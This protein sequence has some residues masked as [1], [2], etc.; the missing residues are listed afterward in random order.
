MINKLLASR[1][2]RIASVIL[3]VWTL[4]WLVSAVYWEGS[5]VPDACKGD[6]VP[7][8]EFGQTEC[9]DELGR[10]HIWVA[11]DWLFYTAMIVGIP[12]ATTLIFRIGRWVFE[13]KK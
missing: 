9:V 11:A 8:L 10:S 1:N 7:L 3:G 6:G 13:G 2:A 4:F 5:G 12:L